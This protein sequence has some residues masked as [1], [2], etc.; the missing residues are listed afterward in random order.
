MGAAYQEGLFKRN[1][2]CAC[3]MEKG[4]AK[5]WCTG[6]GAISSG[7]VTTQSGVVWTRAAIEE[8]SQ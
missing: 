2:M 7:S 3:K 5:G 8:K 4:C 6:E 1:T